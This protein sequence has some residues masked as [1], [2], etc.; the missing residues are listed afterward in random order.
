MENSAFKTPDFPWDIFIKSIRKRFIVF[1]MLLI[2][3]WAKTGCGLKNP[4]EVVLVR[5]AD[6]L[7]NHADIPVRVLDNQSF[8]F[9]HSYLEQV[10]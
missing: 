2:F 4:A 8:G 1:R 10:F 9:L 7:G 6:Q 3:R 5:V